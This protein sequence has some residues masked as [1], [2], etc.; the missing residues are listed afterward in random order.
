MQQK[1][2]NK[3]LLCLGADA[4]EQEIAHFVYGRIVDKACS[5]SRYFDR[6]AEEGAVKVS[7]ERL[8]SMLLRGGAGAGVSSAVSTAVAG[9]EH[10]NNGVA[11]RSSSDGDHS[12]AESC[13]RGNGSADAS[14]SAGESASDQ[15]IGDTCADATT[16]G[17]LIN[18][19]SGGI[20]SAINP[21]FLH[22]LLILLSTSTLRCA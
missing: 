16:G 5:T 20:L 17:T 12:T 6:M 10:S 8:C 21:S 22:V 2:R 13:S 9:V 1:Y 11:T 7:A 14:A 15:K 3:A 4:T 18:N 19:E